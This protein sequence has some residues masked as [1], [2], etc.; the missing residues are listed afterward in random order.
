[1]REVAL[2]RVRA[3]M[4]CVLRYEAKNR[5][6]ISVSHAAKSSSMSW[7]LI[8]RSRVLAAVVWFVIVCSWNSRSSLLVR[9][10]SHAANSLTAHLPQIH[11]WPTA[12]FPARDDAHPR[13]GHRVPR[14]MRDRVR[15]QRALP[16]PD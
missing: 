5:F 6:S 8:H 13:D 11:P 15:P 14:D 12:S 16:R 4:V 7:A 10:R 3:A 9:S 2:Q 1:M